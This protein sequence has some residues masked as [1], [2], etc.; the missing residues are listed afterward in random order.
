M[1]K[2]YS[3]IMLLA[4][5][6]AALSLSACGGEDKDDNGGGGDG[7]SSSATFTITIDGNKHEYLS[8]YL[9]NWGSWENSVIL[10]ETNIG[11]L[12]FQYPSSTTF[13]SFTS[14]Y[15]S[16]AEDVEQVTIGI[17]SPQKCTHSAGLAKVV[18]NDG[19]K[20]KVQFSNYTFTWNQSREIILDGTL[21]IVFR[22]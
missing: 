18:S 16:F 17:T 22:F 21:N 10:I 4:M 15:S 19:K 13:S 2:I 7:G 9:D 1:K 14:G 6:V 5:M 12:R 3:T 8:D 20:M 11:P